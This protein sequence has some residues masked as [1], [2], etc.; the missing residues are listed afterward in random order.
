MNRFFPHAIFCGLPNFM[1]DIHRFTHITEVPTKCA[2][3]PNQPCQHRWDHSL[4]ARGADGCWGAHRSS[5]LLQAELLLLLRLPLR[6]RVLVRLR[7]GFRLLRRLLAR[8]RLREVGDVVLHGL[9]AWS[10]LP[11][12]RS[13]IDALLALDE[14]DCAWRT[15]PLSWLLS[16][17]ASMD[18]MAFSTKPRRRW[19]PTNGV[20]IWHWGVEQKAHACWMK[21]YIKLHWIYMVIPSRNGS[22]NTLGIWVPMQ[23]WAPKKIGH[24]TCFSRVTYTAAT[25]SHDK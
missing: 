1:V 17:P 12:F 24:A 10:S 7:S 13:L 4:A 20:D 6:L 19:Y 2:G 14:L 8:L 25:S 22:P 21:L 18:P 3:E 9:L 11:R 5:S 23:W 16:F 15:L